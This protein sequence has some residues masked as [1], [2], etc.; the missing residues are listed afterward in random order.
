MILRMAKV[1]FVI[2]TTRSNAKN[3]VLYCRITINGISREFST[4][5]QLQQPQC[6][7][8]DKQL[9]TGT[10][11]EAEFINLLCDK[12]KYNVKTIALQHNNSSELTPDDIIRRMK[13]PKEKPVSAAE[14]I[15]SFIQHEKN[16]GERNPGTIQHYEIYLKNFL[17]FEA[18]KTPVESISV[19]WAARFKEFLHLRPDTKD[20]RK[21][22]KNKTRASRHI[23]FYK[24]AFDFAAAN[25][26]I[27]THN[28]V[29]Y[30]AERDKIKPPVYL[31]R[32]EIL[33]LVS[34]KF[35]SSLLRNVKNLYLYQVATGVEYGNIWSDFEVLNTSAGKVISGRRNKGDKRQFYLPYDELAEAILQEYGGKLP[36]LS[37]STYNR[38][39]KEIAAI[40]GINKRLTTHTG[41]KTFAML[42]KGDG[43]SKEAIADMLGHSTT[44]T[45]ET[46]Y[47]GPSMER[48]VNEMAFRSQV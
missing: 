2:R 31:T 43:W 45:T 8:Q 4:E 34:H 15:K 30:K 39:L 29:F 37:N 22:C 28:L 16:Q 12:I 11:H 40:L 9:H 26:I 47:W 35:E 48:V 41:R 33:K 24:K 6:W 5:E 20:D 10:G 25:Q 1:L 7:N 36:R 23:E 46:Y 32:E 27:K 13:A 18:E 38:I 21:R 44:R 17:A 3:S 42:K 19:L 14:L